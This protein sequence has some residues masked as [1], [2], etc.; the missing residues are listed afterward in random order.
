MR[1]KDLL[2]SVR[3]LRNELDLLRQQERLVLSPRAISYDGIRVQT[4]PQDQMLET[5]EA[6]Q[7]LSRLIRKKEEELAMRQ[8]EAMTMIY[9][10]DNSEY[11]KLLLLYYIDGNRQKKWNDVAER[12]GY[13]ESRVKHMHGWALQELE[14]KVSTREHSQSCYVVK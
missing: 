3:S 12:M 6:F 14:K 4:S 7:K 5:V 8:L 10:L 9:S 2:K 13:S 11:R 1:V